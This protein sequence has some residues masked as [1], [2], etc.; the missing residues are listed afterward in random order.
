MTCNN[1]LFVSKQMENY[2]GRS[3]ALISENQKTYSVL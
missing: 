3:E 2:L 1:N